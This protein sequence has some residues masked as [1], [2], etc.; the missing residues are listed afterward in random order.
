MEE[1]CEAL[2]VSDA[3][4]ELEGVTVGVAV[5]DMDGVSVLDWLAVSDAEDESDWVWVWLCDFDPLAVRLCDGDAD[6]LGVVD[7]D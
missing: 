4:D 1:D 3:V 6:G 5:T 7:L 2:V